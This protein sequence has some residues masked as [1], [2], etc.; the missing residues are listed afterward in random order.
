MVSS[1]P[2]AVRRTIEPRWSAIRRGE[3]EIVAD[4]AGEEIGP[5]RQHPDGRHGSSPGSS[6]RSGLPASRISPSVGSQN[7]S[8][9]LARVDFPAP[10][11]PTTAIRRPSPISRSRSSSAGRSASRVD[12][13]DPAKL[14]RRSRHPSGPRPMTRPDHPPQD[15]RRGWRRPDPP[16][17]AARTAPGPPQAGAGRPRT[18]PW[19]RGR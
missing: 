8:S 19:P 9:R 17:Q 3:E 13:A 2:A 15:S 7:R 12:Q 5:L 16:P 18:P 14:D 6:A 4:G 11:G 10:D 1:R